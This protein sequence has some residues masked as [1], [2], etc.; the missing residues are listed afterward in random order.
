[1]GGWSHLSR[2]LL[3]ALVLHSVLAEIS[4]CWSSLFSWGHLILDR[5]NSNGA[6]C[7][8]GAGTLLSFHIPPVCVE[9]RK[10]GE[11]LEGRGSWVARVCT[12]HSLGESEDLLLFGR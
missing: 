5:L 12:V 10:S 4:D 6:S 11:T 7:S 3:P 1:M 8:V 2:Y 9:G